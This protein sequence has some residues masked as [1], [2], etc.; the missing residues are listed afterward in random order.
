MH[1]ITAGSTL[2]CW[3]AEMSCGLN[4][5]FDSLIWLMRKSGLVPALLAALISSTVNGFCAV[6]SIGSADG[7]FCAFGLVGSGAV[8]TTPLF[9]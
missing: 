7:G 1:S 9:T 2:A 4:M 6:E 8:T 5:E 3:A